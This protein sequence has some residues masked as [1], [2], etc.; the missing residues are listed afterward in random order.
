MSEYTPR[1]EYVRDAL[2]REDTTKA[3]PLLRN[4]LRQVRND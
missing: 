4:V 3:T 2:G 1:T